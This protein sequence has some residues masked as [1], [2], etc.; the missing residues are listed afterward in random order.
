MLL[1]SCG[2]QTHDLSAQSVDFRMRT[3]VFG[4][5]SSP[6]CAVYAL[7]ATATDN[8]TGASE[9]MVRAVF[10]NVY[11]DD[12]CCSCES[13]DAAK[14]LISQLCSLLKSGGFHLTKI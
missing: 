4:A 10:K 12:V 2:I 9:E 14:S 6:C 5:K 3:H 11:V 13:V 7:R 8:L 1:D